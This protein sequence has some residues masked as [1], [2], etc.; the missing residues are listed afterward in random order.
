[1]NVLRDKYLLLYGGFHDITH[2]RNDIYLFDLE[3]KEWIGTDNDECTEL[4]LAKNE[5]KS[6]QRIKTEP[7][8]EQAVESSTRLKI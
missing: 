2:E 8:Q 5:Q 7:V 6:F 1:M 4:E 3:K